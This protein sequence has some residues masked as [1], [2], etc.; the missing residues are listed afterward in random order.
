[1][2]TVCIALQQSQKAKFD[3]RQKEVRDSP[4]LN[5]CLCW[6]SRLGSIANAFCQVVRSTF[7]SHQNLAQCSGWRQW[8]VIWVGWTS[9]RGLEWDDPESINE[10]SH[11]IRD[12]ERQKE[13]LVLRS[14]TAS[15]SRMVFK[16]T[17]AD[18]GR[19]RL[20]VDFERRCP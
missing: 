6:V 9:K 2:K 3:H 7:A 20:H 5:I 14:L 1:M 15:Q 17:K 8:N 10:K 4:D 16:P 13:G 18:E 12:W 19:P 11:R